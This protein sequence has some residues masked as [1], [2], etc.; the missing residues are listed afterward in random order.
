M[1]TAS[2]IIDFFKEIDASILLTINSWNNPFLDELMW[3]LTGKL[4]WFPLYAFLLYLVYKNT[5]PKQFVFFF[6]IGAITIGGADFFAN[7]GLKHTIQRYRPSHHL[8]LRD[9]LHFYEFKPGELYKGGLYG[10]VSGH[11]TNS[12]AIAWFF[13]LFL[14]SYYPKI[15]RWLILW[16]II[17]IYTRLYLGVHYPSDLIGGFIVG[18][19]FAFTGN[20][21][22]YFIQ[23]KTL[24]TK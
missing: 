16:A 6:I 2:S 20:K 8:I 23:K 17:V 3:L 22:F 9:L 15:L 24:S 10:F 7:Y 21:L 19:S 13:G 12:F 14:K 1:E 4:I 5:T 11:A 18:T